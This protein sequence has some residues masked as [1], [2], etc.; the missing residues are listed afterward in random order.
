[1]K[2]SRDQEFIE[3][4]NRFIV[5]LLVALA[6]GALC[7]LVLFRKFV[8]GSSTT[9]KIITDKTFV[10]F[11]DNNDCTN[12]NEIKNYLDKEG[13][14]YDVL[15]EGTKDTENIFDSYNIL[16]DESISP[17]VIYVE[18][19]EM[20]ANLVNINSTEE[21]SLFIENYNLNR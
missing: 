13:V 21:L 3:L 4:R 18:K 16:Y 6:I 11:V 14:S 12:C 1:M 10:I 9:R 17:A 2:G 5:G 20:V 7:L 8:F 15:M 19:G